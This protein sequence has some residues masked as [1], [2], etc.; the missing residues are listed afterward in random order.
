[1]SRLVVVSNIRAESHLCDIVCTGCGYNS[2]DIN[3][4]ASDMFFYST[5]PFVLPIYFETGVENTLLLPDPSTKDEGT[6]YHVSVTDNGA[7]GLFALVENNW[8]ILN[9]LLIAQ[10]P[11]CNVRS[12]YL[13]NS[14][15]D[16]DAIMLG[17]IKTS[18]LRSES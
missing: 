18:S 12:G 10:C 5:Y 3:I 14:T 15:D 11:S 7:C 17:R 6:I 16:L 4:D 9:A 1:M 13:I 8:Q 2:S